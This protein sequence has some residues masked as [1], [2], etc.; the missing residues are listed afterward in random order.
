MDKTTAEY[1]NILGD[2]CGKRDIEILDVDCLYR[3]YG[4]KKADV[5]VLFG[6]SILCGGDVLAEAIKNKIAEKYVIVGGAGHTT[7]T[8]RQVVHDRYPEIVT[9]NRPEAE[10]YQK[11]LKAEYGLK[12]DYLETESTNCGNNIT[13][14]LELLKENRIG[15][16]SIILCQDA[17][18]QHRMEAGMRK[19]APEG[20]TVINFASYRAKVIIRDGEP[21][22]EEP[23][24]G[25][26]NMDRYVS[27]LMGEV[28][29]L[30]D[31]REGYGPKGQGFIAHVDIPEKVLIAF[32]KLKEV[33]GENMCRKA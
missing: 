30:R 8:L 20:I 15:T 31:D 23:I 22:Y 2:F 3:K 14:L 18:M 9:E 32:E 33:Y 27:L 6:G 5:F 10:I 24:K 19:Y 1:I 12:A 11:Y 4:I 25:M 21:V 26:W 13:Y 29:R 7:E 17:T 28:P 16:Q